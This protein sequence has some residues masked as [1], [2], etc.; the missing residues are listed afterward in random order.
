MSDATTNTDAA[1]KAY[2]QWLP[3]VLGQARWDGAIDLD[4]GLERAQQLVTIARSEPARS[5]LA[6]LPSDLFE[7]DRVSALESLLL[8]VKHVESAQ[9]ATPTSDGKIPEATLDEA[10]ALRATLHKL[11]DYHFGED[12]AVGAELAEGRPKRS[13]FKIAASLA[14][15]ATLAEERA[16]T[17][18]KDTK[19]WREGLLADARKLADQALAAGGALAEREI[20][21]V[22]RRAFALLEAIFVDIRQAVAFVMRH[23]AAFVEALPTLRKAAVRKAK[24]EPGAPDGSGAPA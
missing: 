16:D 10:E 20:Q 6:L 22:K 12:P 14:R 1:Q 3:R 23:D 18:A 24:A 9:K 4:G 7:T 11:L 13:G 15:L 17:L 5:R 2:A 8:A 19:Y 21:D